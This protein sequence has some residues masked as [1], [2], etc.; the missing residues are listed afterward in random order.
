MEYLG[1]V[2]LFRKFSKWEWYKKSEMV[3]LFLHFLLLANHE[4]GKWQGQIIEKGQ[5]ITGLNSLNE[6]TGI[7]VQTI[8]TCIGRLKSTGEI[9]YK[10]TN[11]NRLITIV[12]WEEYQIKSTSK[13]TGELTN[14]QQTTN[15]QLTA[16]KNDKN[17][18]EC[19][20]DK[21][22]LPDWLNKE[23]W[24]NWLSYRKERKKTLTEQT[25]KLQ[26]KELEKDK[27]NH[28][29]I[30]E[31]S[32]KNGWLGIFPLKKDLTNKN[33]ILKVNNNKYDKFN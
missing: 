10:S 18:K 8:R 16:N 33:N 5:F 14:N 20:E 12:N 25:I 26:L 13:L 28:A 19:K 3:H 23:V 17:N 7:S 22:E 1:Y 2:K 27:P 24:N 21:E 32:I 11:K 29:Q 4:Q 15:K 31:Q 6:D 9:T 30:I